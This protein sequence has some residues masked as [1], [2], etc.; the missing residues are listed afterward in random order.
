MYP[1]NKTPHVMISLSSIVTK[2]DMSLKKKRKK[3]IWAHE[4]PSIG[5]KLDTRRSK[6]KKKYNIYC[7]ALMFSK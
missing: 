4:S 7:H 3:N 5:K 6:K 1:Q 2:R